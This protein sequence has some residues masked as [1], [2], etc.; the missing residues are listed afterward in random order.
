MEKKYERFWFQLEKRDAF[1]RHSGSNPCNHFRH[2]V[3]DG[4]KMQLITLKDMATLYGW[5]GH[6]AYFNTKQYGFPEPVE[7]TP[8]EGK[9]YSREE[10]E[11]WDRCRPVGPPTHNLEIKFTDRTF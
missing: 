3:A 9:L 4:L 2:H 5:R 7:E 11:K 8:E 10:V 1:I 6:S